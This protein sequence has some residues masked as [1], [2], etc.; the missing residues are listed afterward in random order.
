MGRILPESGVGQV[1]VS[2][3]GAGE[4]LL[5]PALYH[6]GLRAFGP[7]LGQAVQGGCL[8]PL[9]RG[10]PEPTS[11]WHPGLASSSLQPSPAG[12]LEWEK[13]TRLILPP[14]PTLRGLDTQHRSFA[15]ASAEELLCLLFQK[16][17]AATGLLV[18]GQ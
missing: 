11:S 9:D 18:P 15:G 2:G 10:E 14:S 5:A 17:Q 8:V 12:Q 13:A 3:E 7:L 16:T 4:R 1:L 6:L